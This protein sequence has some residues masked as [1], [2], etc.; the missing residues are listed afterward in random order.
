MV[1]Q[2]D[3]TVEIIEDSALSLMK[4]SIYT[5][6]AMAVEGRQAYGYRRPRL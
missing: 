2:A 5:G 1:A 3:H 4:M 6:R